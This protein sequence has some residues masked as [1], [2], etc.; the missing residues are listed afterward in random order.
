ME[1]GTY[2]SGLGHVAVI[3]WAMLGSGL[4]P[5]DPAPKMQVSDVS[6]IPAAV[7][8]AAMSNAP[9]PVTDMTTP[10][11]PDTAADRPVPPGAE[12]KPQPAISA[13]PDTPSDPGA[14]PDIP[15]EAPP[16]PTDAQTEAPVLAEIPQTESVGASLIMPDAPI[17]AR[18]SAGHNQPDRLAMLDSGQAP[19]PRVDTRPAPAPEPDAEKSR[20]TEKASTPDPDAETPADATEEKA[21]DQASAEIV[22]EA[23]EATTESAPQKSS[24]PKGRPAK[25]ATSESTATAIERALAEAQKDAAKTS[26]PTPAPVQP[27]GPPLTTAETNGLRLA[28]QECWNVGSLSTDALKVTVTVGVSLDADAKPQTASIRLISS[29]DGNIAAAEQAFEAARRAIIRCGARGYGLPAEK[30]DHWREIEI[31]FNPEKM[32]IR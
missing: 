6:I 5:P 11:I 30:Y 19:A 1:T 24:R 21:P 9:L 2:I 13:A 14:R 28:I 29:S 10:A 8:D 17:A 18:D 3:G 31:T 12:D 26:R 23:K 16:S 25:L 4:M 22:T 15:S 20:D 7:F 27:S 32:R